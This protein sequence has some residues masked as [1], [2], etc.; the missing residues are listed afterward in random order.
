[1][2][3]KKEQFDI[4]G[5][6]CSACSSRVEG[7][8]VKLPGVKDVSVNLLKNSM[9]VSYD[10]AQLSTA[11]IVEAVENSGYGAI[12]KTAPHPKTEAKQQTSAAQAEYKSMKQRLL[13][14]AIFTVPLFYISMGHM[15]NWPLPGWLLGMENAMT[16]AFTQFLLLL[17]VL[18]VNSKYFKVGFRTLLKGSPNMDS[19]IAIGSG[20]AAV[21]GIYAIYKIGIGMGHGDMET[22]HTFMMDLY[23]ESAG[24]I[25]TL[26]TLGKTLEARAKGKTSDAITK[27]MNLAPKVATVER[28]GQEFQIPVEDVQLGEILIVKAGESIPVDGIVVE[29]NSSVDESALTGESIPVEKHIGDKVIGATINKSGYIKMK[30]AKV[31]DDTTLAQIIRLVDEATSS[32][33]PIAKLA[34]KVSGVFV[35]IVIAIALVST[36]AWLIAG[37][38]LEFALSIGIS[39]LVISCPCALGLATPTAIMVGTGKGAANGI[40]I[41]SAE[42]L[43][44]AHSINTVV[45][46]KTGTIT[47]GTPAVTDILLGGEISKQE[48]LQIAASLEKLSEHPLADAIVAEAEKTGYT[49]LPVSDF[50]QIPGQGITGVIHGQL[51]LAG[52]RRLMEAHDVP[53][54]ELMMRGEEL[55]SDGKTPLFFAKDGK[56]L[57]VIAA[58]DVVKP[59]SAQ[60]V[61]QLSD[62]GLEVVM[63]TGDNARTAEAIRRQVGVDRVVAEVFPQ[64]KELEIRR[65]QSEGKKVAMVGDGINDAPALARA[66]VGIAIG[67]GTD[68]AME[69]ADV[70]LMKSDLMDVVTAIQLSKATIR[71]IKQNL[72]WAFIYNIIGIPVAAGLF[73]LPFA[74]KLNPMIGAFAM[75]FSS[76][77]VVT[78]ALR[79]RWFKPK[80]SKIISRIDAT[81]SVQPKG[82]RPMEKTLKIEGMMCSH[83]VMHVQKA[84]AAIPG[85]AEVT[86]SLEEKNAKVK[87]SGDVPDIVFKAAIEQAGYQLTEIA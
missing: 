21:Y 78:N 11:G 86:V 82:E 63:L 14:S 80:H 26:I 87:H 56:L 29:G 3:V 84:L 5:M 31:G 75:S 19:L 49:S 53:G 61:A 1:M 81:A 83:C 17:P 44:T 74:L 4:T 32:K 48:L 9:V 47:Q 70:V 64:D 15:M 37:Y 72:F 54:G 51:V 50:E 67:A 6:T 68:I 23:F 57:G 18:I 39:V 55:A 41:K 13:L 59:T 62:M 77:F 7:C 71:N 42:A 36:I 40:L 73:F 27:L 58:A 65:L 45:L 28:D 43:E 33:A 85:V 79:L 10:E 76:V 16:F 12:P 30:A 69:S 34:D 22:V 25:L 46:D 52:N 2:T 38:G 8:V 24:M 66:D 20:A 35:P 60:A